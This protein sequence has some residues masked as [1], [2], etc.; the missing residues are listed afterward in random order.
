MGIWNWDCEKRKEERRYRKE[1]IDNTSECD[2]V[3]SMMKS[4]TV[5]R[6]MRW[7]AGKEG[8]SKHGGG[9]LCSV[10]GWFVCLFHGREGAGA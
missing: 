2:E 8:I 10:S 7:D 9:K 5:V 4:L 3:R 6:S 1:M